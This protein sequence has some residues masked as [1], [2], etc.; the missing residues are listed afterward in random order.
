MF[1]TRKD[2]LPTK[3]ALVTDSGERVTYG[4]LFEDSALLD[5]ELVKRCLLI[6]LTD[7]SS[8][9]LRFYYAS[10]S[11][12]RVPLL[13]D[14]GLSI[15]FLDRYISLY[16][17]RYVWASVRYEPALAAKGHVLYRSPEH[18]LVDTAEAVYPMHENLALLLTTSGSTGNP[19]VVRLSYENLNENACAIVEALG[20]D[21]NARGVTIPPMHYTY[22]MALCHMHFYAGATLLVTNYRVI[23]KRFHSFIRKEG[24]TNIQ[25]VPFIH[26]MLDRIGFYDDLPPQINL[27]TMGGGKA[28]EDLQQKMNCIFEQKGILF[29]ALYGQTEGTTML[30]RLPEGKK[31]NEPGCIGVACRGMRAEVSPET[32]ELIFYGSSVSL[33]YATC[34]EDLIRGDDNHGVL[35]TGDLAVMDEKGAI[36]LQG[37]IRRFIKM[38]GVRINLDDIEQL[39]TGGFPQIACACSGKDNDL[40]IFVTGKPDP[41]QIKRLVARKLN[42][43]H[44]LIQVI[45]CDQLPRKSNGKIDYQELE[46]RL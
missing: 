26:E 19:K 15:E 14:G 36:Y 29:C 9:T 18:I 24:I 22:G 17:P 23:D 21:Q 31:M 41:T 20:I 16:R 44:I 2:T 30:T 43:S 13:L 7:H 10:M 4:D 25:G 45:D 27:V 38:A 33:G 39:V 35:H 40:H 5:R 42:V 28:R 6:V 34:A 1:L 32:G 11:G 3:E 37:R 46:Q 8:E 12:K